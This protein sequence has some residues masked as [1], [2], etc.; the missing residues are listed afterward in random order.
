[1]AVELNVGDEFK[2]FAEAERAVSDFCVQNY[3]AIRVDSKLSVRNA[4]KKTTE[5]ITTLAD[6]DVCH[7]R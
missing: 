2:T 5:K 4:N 3:H 1:M 6:D 7:C